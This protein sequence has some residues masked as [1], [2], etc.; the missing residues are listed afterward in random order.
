MGA[1]VDGAL[2]RGA[3]DAWVDRDGDGAQ[4]DWA[5]REATVRRDGRARAPGQP[6]AREARR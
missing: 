1:W 6:G 4:G 2:V 5:E 3:Q